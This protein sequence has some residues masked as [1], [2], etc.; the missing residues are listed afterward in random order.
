MTAS[1]LPDSLTLATAT[2]VLP[3]PPTAWLKWTLHRR[4][5]RAKTRAAMAAWPA[6]APGKTPSES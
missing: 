5:G 2:P 1:P 6:P 3:A 4:L